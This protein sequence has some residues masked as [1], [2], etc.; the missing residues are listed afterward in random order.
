MYAFDASL[1]SNKIIL[2]FGVSDAH[3]KILSPIFEKY[4]QDSLELQ[5]LVD[6]PTFGFQ[7]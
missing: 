4:V 6:I 7:F 1:S 2:Y 5:D 3:N